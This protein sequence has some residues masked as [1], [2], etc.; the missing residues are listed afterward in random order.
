[1][2]ASMQHGFITAGRTRGLWDIVGQILG[3]SCFWRRIAPWQIQR[4]IYLFGDCS[5]DAERRELWRGVDLI[6]LE[7]QTFDLLQYLVQNRGRVVSKDDILAGVWNSRIVS[8]STLSSQIAAV[9]RAV[10][11]D[12]GRQLLVRTFP[13]RGFR[14]VGEV[15]EQRE[16]D[17]VKHTTPLEQQVRR[18]EPTPARTERPERRQFTVMVCNLV[19]SNTVRRDPEDLMEFAAAYQTCIKDV[20]TSYDGYI[21]RAVGDEG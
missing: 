17:R 14:F 16:P 9:R 4:M 2:L 5:L 12:G 13:R 21:G 15:K 7:P 8:E 6:T 1:M 3:N 18:P 19:A 10:G 20:V 11:D